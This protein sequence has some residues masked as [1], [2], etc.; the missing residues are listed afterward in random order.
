MEKKKWSKNKIVLIIIIVLSLLALVFAVSFGLIRNNTHNNEIQLKDS[1]GKINLTINETYFETKSSN[2]N[3]SGTVTLDKNLSGTVYIRYNTYAEEDYNLSNSI[4]TG[5]TIAND[6]VWELNKVHVL[7]GN[8][9]VVISVTIGEVVEEQIIDVYYDQGDPY[10]EVS[11]EHIKY[12]EDLKQKYVNNTISVFASDD[13]TEDEL[14]AILKEFGGEIVGRLDKIYD[15]KFNDEYTLDEINSICNELQQFDEI[16]F[17]HP[18]YINNLTTNS[19]VRNST[20]AYKTW[21]ETGDWGF[22]AIEV[23]SAYNYKQRF[24][25]I[26]IAVVDDGFDLKHEDLKDILTP[27]TDWMETINDYKYWDEENKKEVVSSHGTHVVGII[28]A[29]SDNKGITGIVDNVN[30]IYNDWRP[31]KTDDKQ[32]WEEETRILSSLW[33]SVRS[34]AKIINYSVGSSMEIKYTEFLN[35]FNSNRAT[36]NQPQ[37][38]KDEQAKIASYYI[39]SLL[40][41][42]YDFLIVHSSGNG[43]KVFVENESWEIIAVDATNNGIWSCITEDN[44]IGSA[45]EQEK[46][47]ILD[48]III[49]GNAKK[50]LDGNYQQ[51]TDSNGG[52]RVDICAPGTNIFSTTV[53]DCYGLMS[54][55]SMAAPHVTGVCG[56]VWSVNPSFTGAEVKEIVCNYTSITVHDNPDGKHPLENTYPMVNAKLAVEEAIRRTDKAGT[57]S[58]FV[59]DSTTDKAIEGVQIS[60]EV[61]NA[62]RNVLTDANGNFKIDL[63]E[64]ECELVFEYNGYVTKKVTAI[65]EKN[66]STMLLDTVYLTPTTNLMGYVIEKETDK[67]IEDASILLQQID[68]GGMIVG[69][70]TC[71]TDANGQFSVNIP[72]GTYTYTINKLVMFDELY[73]TATGTVT[74]EK[75]DGNILGTVYLNPKHKIIELKDYLG[76]NIETETSKIDGMEKVDVSYGSQYENDYLT[77]CSEPFSSIISFVSIDKT[78]N[79]SI[80]NICIGDDFKTECDKLQEDNWQIVDNGK[81]ESGIIENVYLKKDEFEIRIY[82]KNNIVTSINCWQLIDYI[83]VNTSLTVEQAENILQKAHEI[84]VKWLGGAGYSP[85]QTIKVGQYDY[86]L[87]PYTHVEM[88]TEICSVFHHYYYEDLF[89]AFYTEQNGKLYYK[90]GGFGIEGLYSCTAGNLK[91]SN[92]DALFTMHTVYYDAL[93]GTQQDEQAK[94]I[95]FEFVREDGKWVI[96]EING[97]Y[98]ESNYWLFPSLRFIENDNLIL[99]TNGMTVPQEAVLDSFGSEDGMS[100]NMRT[101]PGTNNSIIKKIPD[102]SKVYV[103]GTS[104]EYPDWVFVCYLGDFGWTIKSCIFY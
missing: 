7:P 38:W 68:E 86:G 47:D 75:A 40:R 26:N 27:S 9:K 71:S 92:S 104:E 81:D 51:A 16:F 14:I 18:N 60:A 21:E 8:S 48:R 12:D 100:V 53:N 36:I 49:V 66:V 95:Q 19:D 83:T 33:Y 87:V 80:F 41:D 35:N 13:I 89:E 85:S 37:E 74:V 98:L 45:T 78:C 97:E 69:E 73:E 3:L 77:F 88:K 103:C 55:T 46:Q 84:V 70:I 91:M 24:S 62:K 25:N 64:G 30:I 59:K 2:I 34:G 10:F 99:P 94:E 67:P 39:L 96:K 23:P 15:V 31:N 42:G 6:K 76:K 90:I 28:G 79:Y 1:F 58:G 17:A 101:G 20:I 93:G 11:E 29:N 50:N 72:V 43:A 52:E 63:P 82:A 56:L 22:E 44:I 4:F 65:S 57:I 32:T 54:G 5:E 102:N 61:G